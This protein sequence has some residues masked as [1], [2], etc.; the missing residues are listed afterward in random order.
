MEQ[1]ENLGG[2]VPPVPPWFLRLCTDDETG[3]WKI[4]P[5]VQP[6]EVWSSC[7]IIRLSTNLLSGCL[8]LYLQQISKE[9]VDLPIS[10]PDA[11]YTIARTYP[12]KILLTISPPTDS[13]GF[14]VCQLPIS[15]FTK[16]VKFTLQLNPSLRM[17]TP[18]SQLNRHGLLPSIT[19][20]ETEHLSFSKSNLLL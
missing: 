9:A 8:S 20:C 14:R 15:G 16:E 12:P 11:G 3:G 17:V 19:D 4:I 2:H 7:T 1:T 13:V 6:C 18:L 10:N 5:D